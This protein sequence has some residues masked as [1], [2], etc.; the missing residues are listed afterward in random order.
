[1]PANTSK[2][3]SGACRCDRN[4]GCCER[5]AQATTPAP[6]SR[7]PG[8]FGKRPWLY[9]VVAFL[10]MFSAWTVMFTV[11]IKHQPKSVPFATQEK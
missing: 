6:P 9:V 4:C 10:I 7:E 5:K 3:K 1:M 11:A 2:S 8:F